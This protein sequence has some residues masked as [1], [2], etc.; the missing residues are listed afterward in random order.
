LQLAGPL[1]AAAQERSP[2]CVLPLRDHRVAALRHAGGRCRSGGASVYWAAIQ[3]DVD[4]KNPEPPL[5]YYVKIGSDSIAMAAQTV[6]SAVSRIDHYCATDRGL[7]ASG[8][9]RHGYGPKVLNGRVTQGLVG[10]PD[11][12][13]LA[14]ARPLFERERLFAA[15]DALAIAS[16]LPCA[17]RTEGTH[18]FGTPI[19]LDARGRGGSPTAERSAAFYRLFFGAESRRDAESGWCA[20]WPTTRSVVVRAPRGGPR[21]ESITIASTWRAATATTVAAKLHRARRTYAV[22]SD[23]ADELHYKDRDGIHVALRAA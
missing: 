19:A 13:R 5:R 14:A 20:S 4:Q 23:D 15:R 17:S 8:Y 6:T 3:S 16:P 12:L 2:E 22:V 10:D 21:R 1:L 18:V 9:D 7:S 11:G